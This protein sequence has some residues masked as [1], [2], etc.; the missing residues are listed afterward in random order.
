MDAR[1]DEG[2]EMIEA[3]LKKVKE[4]RESLADSEWTDK[5][6]GLIFQYEYIISVLRRINES[7]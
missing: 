1:A 6:R 5:I 4:I 7:R 3:E 2:E